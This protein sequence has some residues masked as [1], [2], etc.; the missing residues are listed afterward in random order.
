M[1]RHAKSSDATRVLIYDMTPNE[2]AAELV[3]KVTQV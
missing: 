2:L 1:K 3:T